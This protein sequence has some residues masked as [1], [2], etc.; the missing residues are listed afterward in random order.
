[1]YQKNNKMFNQPVFLF[2]NIYGDIVTTELSF[3]N[4]IQWINSYLKEHKLT[5]FNSTDCGILYGENIIQMNFNDW[6]EKYNTVLNPPTFPLL[7]QI[8]REIKLGNDIP[9]I[10]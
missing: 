8:Y 1:M 7:Y 9:I 10:P 4:F 2:P 3:I 6:C 5:V